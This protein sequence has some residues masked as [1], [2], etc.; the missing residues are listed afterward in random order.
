MRISLQVVVQDEGPAPATVTEIA[1][2]ERTAFDAGSLGLHLAEAKA[3]LGGL[4]RTMEGPRQSGGRRP[5][6]C[7]A[8]NEA[9]T[10]RAW[11]PILG[12]RSRFFNF[13]L[14]CVA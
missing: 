13:E 12:R 11:L 4:Q 8:A 14:R 1:Q 7:R 2:F 9:P 3:L 5:D 6:R 10:M